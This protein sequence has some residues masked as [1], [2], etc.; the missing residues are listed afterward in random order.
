MNASTVTRL[1]EDPLFAR[2]IAISRAHMT[3]HVVVL[4]KNS[5]E[6]LMKLCRCGYE[7]VT[8]H[9]AD[10]G[11]VHAA[12]PA[13]ALLIPN[14][15]DA[16]DLAATVRFARDLRLGGRL[17]VNAPTTLAPDSLR[18]LQHQLQEHGFRV[19]SRTMGT[20]STLLCAQR[21]VFAAHAQAA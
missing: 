14:A 10:N 15:D 5:F 18:W 19:W 17:V 8:C 4:G 20:S 16:D 12:G 7:Q 21:C 9:E 1:P 13:D 6:F 2:M 3:S 11:P